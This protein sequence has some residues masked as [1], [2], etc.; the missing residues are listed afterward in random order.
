MFKFIVMLAVL[1]VTLASRKGA[2]VSTCRQGEVLQECGCDLNC[3]NRDALCKGV[4]YPEKRC[5]CAPRYVRNRSKKCIP[6]ESCPSCD[7]SE[8]VLSLFSLGTNFN[9]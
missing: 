9:T 3:Q 1:G 2:S 7:Q 4:C 6:K 8:F 5:F